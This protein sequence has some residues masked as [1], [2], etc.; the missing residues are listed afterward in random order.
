MSERRFSIHRSGYAAC[1]AVLLGASVVHAQTQPAPAQPPAQQPNELPD[2][3]SLLGIPSQAPAPAATGD[4]PAEADS[5]PAPEASS[6]LKRQLSAEEVS[7]EFQKA[8]GLMGDAS[9]RLAAR[10]AGLDTQRLQ[11]DILRKLDALIEQ[12]KQNQSSSSSKKK[13]Q[14]Q[15]PS[16]KSQSAQSSQKGQ[17]PGESAR[18]ANRGE[19]DNPA[20]QA[21]KPNALDPAPA[22]AWGNLPEHVRQSL[23]QGLSDKFSSLYQS[24][25]EEYYRRL[26]EQPREDDAAPAPSPAPASTPSPSTEPR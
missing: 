9:K 18:G 16:E 22:A 4:K 12:A 24:V 1:V 25:T 11:E 5:S 3:D 13:K 2:L 7:D 6:E 20:A 23:V 17:K 8:V 14:S 26:A 15:S 19:T 10:D 21:A